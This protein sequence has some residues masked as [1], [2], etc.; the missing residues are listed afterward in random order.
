MRGLA[1]RI[2]FG[3]RAVT[4]VARL[5]VLGSALALAACQTDGSGVASNGSAANR[6]LA[7]ESI[8][9]PPKEKFDSLVSSLA[10]EAEAKQVALV[11]R[12]QPASY[13]IRGYMSVH[14]EKG[15]TQVAY[16]WEVFD[17]DKQRVARITGEETAKSVKGNAWNVCDEAMLQRIAGD[18]IASLSQTLSVGN[19]NA[20]A[21]P[22]S[23]PGATPAAAAPAAEPAQPEAPA[24]PVAP[25][26]NGGVP[27][28]S[29]TPGDSLASE[30]AAL[31]YASR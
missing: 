23:G 1:S 9:G 15:K 21:A 6:A 19:P 27:V 29:L 10:T 13:R 3:T 5:A 2:G 26:E 24:V 31:A 20:V 4:F 25:P 22:A 17:A 8:D 30:P 11:S 12:T 28:A 16:A 18:T 7:F 14:T